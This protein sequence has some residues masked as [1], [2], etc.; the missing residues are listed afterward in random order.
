MK[1]INEIKNEVHDQDK[2]VAELAFELYCK[3]KYRELKDNLSTAE[4]RLKNLQ[5][6]DSELS[7]QELEK[8]FK[9]YSPQGNTKQIYTEKAKE[10]LKI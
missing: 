7:L 3:D 9:G 6:I 10:K 5:K 8:S 4:E 2:Q 1:S